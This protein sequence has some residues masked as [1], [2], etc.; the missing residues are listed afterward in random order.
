MTVAV[1]QKRLHV[2]QG[3]YLV[4]D[5]PNVVLSTILGS[6]VAACLRDPVAGVGGMNHFL[7]PGEAGSSGEATRYG[8]HLME[9]LINGL[10][11][12]G[13]KK[14]R[15][16]AKV[17]GGAQTMSRLSDVG[18]QNGE[19]AERFLTDEAIP[20]VNASLGGELGRKV[21]FWPVSGRAR[22]NI[23]TGTETLKAVALEAPAAPKK[24]A[25]DDI[26]FF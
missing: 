1:P 17:F 24:P 2:I 23:L 4:S 7:L 16:E 3:K 22:Q 5:D 26:E 19:F 6:C 10:L 25:P 15:L 20:I 14:D 13:A 11:Q 9:L 21:E 8:V 12:K 18:R